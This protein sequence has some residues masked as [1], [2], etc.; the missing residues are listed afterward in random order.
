MITLWLV[1]T[2]LFFLGWSATIDEHCPLHVNVSGNIDIVHSLAMGIYVFDHFER[3]YGSIRFVQQQRK[4]TTTHQLPFYI[5][6]AAT[7]LGRWTIVMGEAGI[8]RKEGIFIS[9]IEDCVN[10][11]DPN[12]RWLSAE[13]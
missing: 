10:P 11:I 13:C 12:L 5:Y 3:S 8:K 4:G 7:P 2:H 1:C 6:R 9:R